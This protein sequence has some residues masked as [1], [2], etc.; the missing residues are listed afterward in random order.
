[1][2]LPAAKPADPPTRVRFGV[3]WLLCTLAMLSYL[4]RVCFGA[5]APT[6]AAE[7][8]L[9]GGVADLKWAFTAFAI[10]YAVFEVP[11]GWLGDRLGGKPP[12]SVPKL[13]HFATDWVGFHP[14]GGETGNLTRRAV[15]VKGSWPA[16]FPLKT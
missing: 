6:I 13:G 3:L 8:G 12:S 9:T 10:A 7:L 16:D 2:T 11:V 1:M 5:A 14:F 15:Y 4:D